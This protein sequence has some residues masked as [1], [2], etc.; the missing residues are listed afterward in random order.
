MM[1]L[2]K[3]SAAHHPKH[4]ILTV[5]HGGG[6]GG[7]GIQQKWIGQNTIPFLGETCCPFDRKL[8]IGQRFTFKH[9]NGLCFAGYESFLC[10]LCT[11]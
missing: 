2:A 3:A 4:T 11:V 5:K 8:E 9:D 7:G 6:G 10:P 1:H